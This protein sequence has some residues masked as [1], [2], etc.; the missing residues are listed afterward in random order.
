[1]QENGARKEGG[2]ALATGARRPASAAIPLYR[3]AQAAGARR[4]ETPA[5]AP[6]RLDTL[7]PDVLRDL[8]DGARDPLSA[9]RLRVIADELDGQHRELAA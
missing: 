5:C 1:M 3:A 4:S 7:V 6:E 9:A 2:V 8:A